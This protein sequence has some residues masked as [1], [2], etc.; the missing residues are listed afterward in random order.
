MPTA[1]RL[2]RIVEGRTTDRLHAARTPT[3]RI[4]D[5]I[6]AAGH[7]VVVG[8]LA[9]GRFGLHAHIDLRVHGTVDPTRRAEIKRIVAAAMRGAG[10]PCDLTFARDLSAA[11]R[12]TFEHRRIRPSRSSGRSSNGPIVSAPTSTSSRRSTRRAP[13]LVSVWGRP[14]AAAAAVRDA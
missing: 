14:T 5:A 2:E 9:G 1:G 8:S 12:E 7:D 4:R 6:R 3:R 10:I 13:D 11:Q